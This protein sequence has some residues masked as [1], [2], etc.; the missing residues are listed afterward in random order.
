MALETRIYQKEQQTRL[1]KLLKTSFQD[2]YSSRFLSLQ[3][4][5]RDIKAQYRQSYFG[6]VWAFITPLTT[7][8]VW[9][10]LNQTGVITLTATG[11]P[12]PVYAFT[13]TLIWS[14]LI[15]SINSPTSSTNSARSILSK[16][17][18]PKE[19]LIVSGIYKL[20]FNSCVKLVLIVVFLMV[21]GVPLQGL[22]LL[23]PL[24]LLCV[25]FFGTSVGLLITPLGL[26]YN[27]I[28]KMIGLGM[29]FLMYAS[30]VVYVV[31]KS[32]I[33]KTIM[34]WNP[35]TALITVTRDLIIG[36][37]FDYLYYFMWVMMASLP[38]F[39]IALLFYRVSIPILVERMN[40]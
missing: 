39:L 31:P 35:L 26:L 14:I 15:D 33:M 16:I 28:A 21:Y 22:L 12:Y 13:G 3:L 2:I 40:A 4:A 18:F 10:F 17:N 5:K 1:G 11:V 9:I 32:G 19:A 38:L 25:V 7:A 27:D 6:I 34:E 30:P 29:R 36:G 37:A 24:A 8:L 20:L 23:F